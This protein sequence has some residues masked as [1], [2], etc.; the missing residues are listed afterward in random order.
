M[1]TPK[2]N[3]RLLR[4]LHSCAR[5]TLALAAQAEGYEA[6]ITYMLDSNEPTHAATI[7]LHEGTVVASP[8]YQAIPHRHTNRLDYDVN[9]PVDQAVLDRLTVLN[10]DSE[11]RVIRVTEPEARIHMGEQ[12]VAAT[13]ALIADKQQSID[14]HTWWRDSF[15]ND[16]LNTRQ[17]FA[18]GFSICICVARSTDTNPEDMPKIVS[19]LWAWTPASGNG[20][21][22]ITS[23]GGNMPLY[24]T[25]RPD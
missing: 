4:L 5:C 9:R 2:L 21:F 18:L 16:D 22:T 10:D 15:H 23:S 12:I 25:S 20:V 17:D 6:A 8:L 7:A 1:Y 19:Q 14:I 11:V 3:N 24:W 13:A